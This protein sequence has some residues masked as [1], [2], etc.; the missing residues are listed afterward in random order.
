MEID[1]IPA[2]VA[3]EVYDDGL[4]VADHVLGPGRLVIGDLWT[5]WGDVRPRPRQP[6]SMRRRMW[7]AAAIVGSAV[8]VGWVLGR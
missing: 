3:Y 1:R 2:L 8:A 4:Y 6:W 5:E 7:S